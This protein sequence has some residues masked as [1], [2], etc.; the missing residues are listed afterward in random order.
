MN[1]LKPI[2]IR[3]TTLKVLKQMKLD[4]SND[5]HHKIHSID[6][7]IQRLIYLATKYKKNYVHYLNLL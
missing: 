3:S 5:P 4:W 7:V 2:K 6:D 1:N